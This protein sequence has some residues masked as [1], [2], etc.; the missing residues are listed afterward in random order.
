MKPHRQPS[1]AA[2]RI[3]LF[4]LLLYALALLPLGMAVHYATHAALQ[5]QI[6]A[7]LLQLSDTLRS[8]YRNDGVRGVI[9]VMTRLHGAGPV[10]Q[11]A[12]L[13]SPQGQRL[14]GNIETVMPAPGWQRILLAD[15]RE[16][17]DPA[18]ALVSVLPDG[19]RLVVAADLESL[20]VIDRT[21]LGMFLV[22]GIA[23]LLLGA[24][25]AWLLARYLQNRLAPLE[26][27]ATAVM[28]GDLT[29]RARIGPAGD[30]FDRA[31]ASLNAMLDRIS[32]L[33]GQLRE[34]SADLAHDLRTPLMRLRHSLD[35]LRTIDDPV[36][37]YALIDRTVEQTEEVLGLFDAILRVS[38]VDS[39]TLASH[40]TTVDVS[41]LLTDLAESVAAAAE[42]SGHAIQAQI[43]PGL[44]LH[45]DRQLLAQAVLNL[46][47]NA[48]RHT[49]VGCHIRLDAHRQDGDLR[50]AVCDDGPGI[51]DADRDRVRQ[52]F[53]RLDR[54][55]SSP[56]HGLGLSLVDAIARAHGGRLS[57][58]AA[59][60]GLCAC[61]ELPLQEPER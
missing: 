20:E 41:D 1:S 35:A 34:V 18:L 10:P 22:T 55:R 60:P 32:A 33:V 49:P 5:R 29:T 58:T 56:G 43:A 36:R 9:Q 19:N 54:A 7:N 40:F 48:L 52:R 30:E 6:Q 8:D 46:I 4:G 38:E 24:V 21:L 2:R 39:G 45:G 28:R 42:D 37:R 15:P 11:G 14:G 47:E 31:A 16:G 61:L 23:L 51:P 26:A 3:A 17:P 27:T 57:L 12:A 13:F 59:R 25:A 53:V 50:I 44:R